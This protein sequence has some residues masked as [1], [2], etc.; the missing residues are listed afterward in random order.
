MS[1]FVRDFNGRVDRYEFDFQH[2]TYANG[3][4]QIDTYQDASY[5]GVWTNPERREIVTYC[6]GDITMEICDDDNDYRRACVACL[7]FYSTAHGLAPARIDCKANPAMF[8]R[9]VSLGL[10]SYLH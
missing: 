7:T 8:D 9:F 3:W 1:T 6:E 5:F 4:A 2:C 10:A